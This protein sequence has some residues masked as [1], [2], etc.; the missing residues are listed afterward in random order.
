MIKN[1]TKNSVLVK[2][3]EFSCSAA[4]KAKGLMFRQKL[5]PASGFLMEFRYEGKHGIWMPFMRFPIDIV[6]IGSDKK[7]VD[8]K[9][10]VSPM[11]FDPRTWRVY[12]P[13]EKC[14]YVLEVNAGRARETGLE[15]G[16]ALE[17]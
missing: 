2:E 11:G 15:N 6:F 13:R 4:G 3:T 14:R 9:H 8:I 17:F 12:R 1:M 5:D 16:D 7:V 10:S